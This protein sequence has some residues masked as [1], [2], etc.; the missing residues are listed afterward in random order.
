MTSFVNSAIDNFGIRVVSVLL[1]FR[2]AFVVYRLLSWSTND[3]RWWPC[4]G[5][6]RPAADSKVSVVYIIFDVDFCMWLFVTDVSTLMLSSD[7]KN[8]VLSAAPPPFRPSDPT[9]CGSCPL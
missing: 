2:H 1:V 4:L 6:S 9:L 7:V 3:H 8:L 5:F